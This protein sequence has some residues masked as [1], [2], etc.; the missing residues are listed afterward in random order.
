MPS[1]KK[2]KS[3]INKING[4]YIMFPKQ[5][6]NSEIFKN[7]KPSTFKIYFCLLTHWLRNG[8]HGNNVIISI[9]SIEKYT[10]ISRATIW[11]SLKELKKAE[12]IDYVSIYNKTTSYLLNKK[13]THNI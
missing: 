8:K 2:K 11:R 10:K 4:D 7:L 13:Y 5:S 9:E 1:K 6:L 3:D 12:I